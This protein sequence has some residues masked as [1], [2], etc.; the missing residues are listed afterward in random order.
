MDAHRLT[1]GS[2][3]E[4]LD[5]LPG[6]LPTDPLGVGFEYLRSADGSAYSLAVRE[7][8]AYAVRRIACDDQGIP[9]VEP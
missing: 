3:P 9:R 7:P 8:S 6:Q 2:L 1:T 5:Q 4:R